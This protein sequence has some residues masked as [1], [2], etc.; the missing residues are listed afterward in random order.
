LIHEIDS[1]DLGCARRVLIPI[2]PIGWLL[3]VTR[4]ARLRQP[5]EVIWKTIT[6]LDAMPAWRQGL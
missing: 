1:V 3:P 6:D 4:E 5:P 2:T